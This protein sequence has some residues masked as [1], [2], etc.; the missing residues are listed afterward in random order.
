MREIAGVRFFSAI[1]LCAAALQAPLQ[2]SSKP[3]PDLAID[4]SPGS[5][6]YGAAEQLKAKGDMAGWRTTLEYLIARY[7]SSRFAAM[8]KQDL[9]DAGAPS[10]KP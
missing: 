8:A 7:P 4:E 10:A 6:V 9:G 5:A 1:V 2:C 3:P